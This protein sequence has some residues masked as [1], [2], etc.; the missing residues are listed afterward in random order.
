V[1][2]AMKWRT[3]PIASAHNTSGYGEVTAMRHAPNRM[4][5]PP[6]IATR[7]LRMTNARQRMS[8]ARTVRDIR[9]DGVGVLEIGEGI[10]RRE[11]YTHLPARARLSAF[12]STKMRFIINA[13]K[14]SV[15]SG[16]LTRAPLASAMP[17]SSR[18]TP[19]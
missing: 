6:D 12:S 1:A 11:L 15:T 14:A 5:N 3:M 2:G 10:D 4:R 18:T 7:T 13:P 17:A 19:T 8:T 16:P 9:G